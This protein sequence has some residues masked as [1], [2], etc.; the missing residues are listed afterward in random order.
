M[1]ASVIGIDIDP[2]LLTGMQ[3]RSSGG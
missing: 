2:A 3:A 1:P